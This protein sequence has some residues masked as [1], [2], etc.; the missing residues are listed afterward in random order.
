MTSA[1]DYQVGKRLAEDQDKLLTLARC[2][3][4]LMGDAA[5]RSASPFGRDEW[6]ELQGKLAE[7][8]NYEVYE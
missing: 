8:F 4:K 3:Y 1:R 7:V 2:V 5:G 6:E